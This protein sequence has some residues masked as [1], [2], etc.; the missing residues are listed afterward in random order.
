MIDP[1]GCV[2]HGRGREAAAVNA[3]VDLAAQQAGGFQNSQ[4][5][6][7]RGKRDVEW[8]GKF[9]D[10]G[11]SLRETG[12][13]GAARGIGEGVEDA[14]DSGALRRRIVNHMV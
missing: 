3:A 12:E 4:V 11:L 9:A 7:D 10:G 13:D 6:G 2:F 1:A 8:F 14:I 5:L